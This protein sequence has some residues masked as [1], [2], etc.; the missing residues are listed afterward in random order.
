MPVSMN[1]TVSGRTGISQAITSAA[2]TG[3]TR[4]DINVSAAVM[5][6]YYNAGRGPQK[7]E[8]DFVLTTTLTD[9]IS[10]LVNT[11]VVSGT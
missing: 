3:I 9:S 2:I 1:A 5:T 11:V 7:I 4:V 6:V 8:L 10:S